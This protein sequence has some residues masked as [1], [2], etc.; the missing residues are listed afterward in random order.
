MKKIFLYSI[1]IIFACCFKNNL[2]NAMF[3]EA[4]NLNTNS[5]KIEV[6]GFQNYPPFG[7]IVDNYVSIGGSLEN[8]PAFESV[9]KFIL[10][11]IFTIHST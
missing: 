1:L 10:E 9:F 4:E 6:S 5:R 8:K 11:K 3:V 7:E 2:V